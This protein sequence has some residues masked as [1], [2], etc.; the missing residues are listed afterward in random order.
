MGGLLGGLGPLSLRVSQVL[1]AFT[2]LQG[3]CR[4]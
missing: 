1:L 4:A 2:A 3:A